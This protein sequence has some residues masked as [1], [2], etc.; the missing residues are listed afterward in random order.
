MRKKTKV[1][2]VSDWVYANLEGKKIHWRESF[3]E[4]IEKMLKGER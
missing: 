4:V 3:N 1:I 2:R